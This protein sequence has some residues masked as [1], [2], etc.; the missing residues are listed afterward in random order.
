MYPI[1]FETRRSS[2]ELKKD[3]NLYVSLLML[4]CG[5]SEQKKVKCRFPHIFKK[6]SLESGSCRTIQLYF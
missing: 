3:N 2:A 6:F 5:I 4:C 1:L